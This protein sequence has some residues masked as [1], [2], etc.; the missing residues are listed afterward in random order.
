MLRFD[1]AT[2]L[3]ILI[4]SIISARLSNNLGGS[5]VLLSFEFIDI[6]PI[7]YYDCKE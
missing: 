4:K 6:A 3:L 7:S 5:D 1:K 2:Y